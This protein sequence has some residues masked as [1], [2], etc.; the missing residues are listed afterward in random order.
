MI[1]SLPRWSRLA[2]AVLA[3]GACSPTPPPT[4]PTPPDA[5]TPTDA[6]APTDA[7]PPPDAGT[8]PDAGLPGDIYSTFGTHND[9]HADECAF[10]NCVFTR[11]PDEPTNPTYPEYWTSHWTMYRVFKGYE[12][13]PPP[14]DKKPPAALKDGADYQTSWG[15]TYYDSTWVGPGAKGAMMEHYDKFCLPIFPIANN[16]TCSFISL[17]DIAF[18]VAADDRPSWMPPV[19]LFSPKN[20]P[21]ERDFIKHL[22]YSKADSQRLAVKAQAYSFW[23]SQAGK[24]MQTGA[25]PDRTKDEDILFGYA[26]DATPT[27]DRVDKTAA[28]YRHPQSFYFSGFPL[29]PPSAPIVSQNYTDFAMIRPDPAATWAQVSGLDPRTLPKCQLFEPPTPASPEALVAR[30]KA[31]TWGSIGRRH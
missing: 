1:P 6:G 26:F 22:P 7:G 31:P 27:P 21:P 16:F 10:P 18:F 28:P 17:G 11:A 19:C 23:V 4:P 25:K 5:G 29:D 12:N 24:M 8:P 3:L 2:G 20:H 13:N 14:Y 15:A 9:A 30:K